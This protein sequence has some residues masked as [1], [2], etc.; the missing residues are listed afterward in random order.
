MFGRILISLI[1]TVFCFLRA[2]DAFFCA[3]NL[4]LP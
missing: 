1:S 3:W 2:S 4:Y